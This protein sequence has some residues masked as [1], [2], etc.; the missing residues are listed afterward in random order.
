MVGTSGSGKTTVGRALAARLDVPF[1]ELDS[2]FHQAGWTELPEERAWTKHRTY[3]E[4]YADAVEDPANAHLT[5]IRVRS[6]A[7]AHL[8]TRS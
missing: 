8:L 4:R 1:V 3:R 7:E 2:V 5:F 6:R